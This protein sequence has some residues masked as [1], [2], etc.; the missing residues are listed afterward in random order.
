MSLPID[1]SFA[2]NGAEWN[3]G[4]IGSVGSVDG[5]TGTGG[6]GG[7]F[8]GVLG[9]QLETLSASQTDAAQQSQALATGE[10]SD[11]TQVVMSVERA[12]LEMQL[13]TTLRNK[14]VEA[15]QELMRTQV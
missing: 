7:S 8:G 6:A 10:A 2:T 11:P 13:A 3:V 5:T 15:I 4:S 14:G 9:K 12:Q 1:T